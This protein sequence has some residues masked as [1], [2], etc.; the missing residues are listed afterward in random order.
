MRIFAGMDGG[1]TRT[2]LVLAAETGEILGS[3]AGGSCNFTD[4][5]IERAQA[6]MAR[7]WNGAWE[8]AGMKPRPA[9]AIF[10]GLGSILSPQDE[11]VNREIAVKIGLAGANAVFAGNDVLNAHAAGLS[12]QPGILLIAGTG[13]A[14]YGRNQL[15]ESWRTGGWGHLLGEQG[16]AYALGQ[17]ALIAATRAADERGPATALQKLVGDT[18]ALG[19]MKEI[20]SRVHHVRIA[21]A[22]LAAMAPRVVALAEAGDAVA[23]EIIDEEAGGLVE[24]VITVARKLKIE[25]PDLALTGGLITQALF[26]RRTFLECLKRQLPDFQLVEG[27]LAPVFGAVLLAVEHGTGHPPAA[28]FLQ[29]LLQSSVNHAHLQ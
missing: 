7:L 6:G 9:T 8:A 5:G 16:S 1:G 17:A 15:N 28:E 19:D 20:F 12:G 21:R 24:M 14:C 3:A 22:E 23:R 10:M 29:K 27:G 13:S 4:L 26:F 2:R 18:L 25:S 11:H